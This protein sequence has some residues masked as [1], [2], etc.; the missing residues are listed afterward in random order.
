MNNMNKMNFHNINS[1]HNNP[2]NRINLNINNPNPQNYKE[3]NQNINQFYYNNPHNQ[4]SNNLNNINN[5]NNS[6]NLNLINSQMSNINIQNN[7]PPQQ[8]IHNINSRQT[9]KNHFYNTEIIDEDLFIE[10]INKSLFIKSENNPNDSFIETN[11]FDSKNFSDLNSQ[12]QM[13]LERKTQ[14][15]IKDGE[16]FESFI[17]RIGRNL[18]NLIKDQKGS[19]SMQ[20]FLDKIYPEHV[21]ILLNQIK[22]DM[23]EI[24]MDPYGNYF[25]QKLIQCSSLNQRNLI[26]DIVKDFFINYF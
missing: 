21:N 6:L 25:I 18:K 15:E 9:N 19:R 20:N 4:Q 5:L 16:S 12:N 14:Y 11:K 22:S 7:Q 8:Y 2:N 17:I 13:Y 3:I 10:N 24:M 23:K 1:T 26:F